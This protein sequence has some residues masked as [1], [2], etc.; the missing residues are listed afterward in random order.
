MNLI[1]DWLLALSICHKYN[2]KWNPFH[3]MKNAEC[4]YNFGSRK[5]VVE[6]NPF[7][8]KFIDSFMHEVGH[9]RRWDKIYQNTEGGEFTKRMLF[10]DQTNCIL[11]EEYMAWKYSKRFLKERF[12]KKRAKLF[13]KS[14]YSRSAKEVTAMVATDRYYAF[15]RNI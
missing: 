3:N 12:D 14:Y 13:F 5:M 4:G 7:Y 9:L 10:E 6:I 1:K 2:I 15:D 11:K 8:P